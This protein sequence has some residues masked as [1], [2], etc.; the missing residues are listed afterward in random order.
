MLCRIVFSR[1]QLF[2]SSTPVWDQP[3]VHSSCFQRLAEAVTPCPPH[4]ASATVSPFPSFALT[5]VQTILRKVSPH[6][7]WEA[8]IQNGKFQPKWLKSGKVTMDKQEGRAMVRTA[9]CHLRSRAPAEPETCP[10]PNSLGSR[11][12]RKQE[13][14]LLGYSSAL[15]SS[16]CNYLKIYACVY[17]YKFLLLSGVINIKWKIESC[18]G[19]TTWNCCVFGRKV[20]GILSNS[21][22]L[23]T[24]EWNCASL[25][26]GNIP[27]R[28]WNYDYQ[29][30][31]EEH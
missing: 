2:Q 8:E 3:Y 25:V 23:L 6:V 18:V 4:P 15:N 12:K 27:T 24:R 29:G 1:C 13:E 19:Q 31:W 14:L 28:K 7:R 9:R 5:P 10:A 30:R 16:I 20:H 17:I 11:G 22:T 26:I 21:W